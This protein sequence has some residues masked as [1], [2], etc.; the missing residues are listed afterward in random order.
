MQAPRIHPRAILGAAHL[1]PLLGPALASCICTI[2]ALLVNVRDGMFDHSLGG[3]QCHSRLGHI[4]AHLDQ[5]AQTRVAHLQASQFGFG[6]LQH[7]TRLISTILM[8][9]HDGHQ[10]MQPHNQRLFVG[11]VALELN[12]AVEVFAVAPLKVLLADV[13]TLFGL[14]QLGNALRWTTRDSGF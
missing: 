8:K 7:Y 3:A 13:Q 5:C 2:L 11:R 1:Q 6:H 10:Q 12:D 9:H 14:G 4:V